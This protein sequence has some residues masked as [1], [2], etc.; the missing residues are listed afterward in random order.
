[1]DMTQGEGVYSGGADSGLARAGP[2]SQH[3]H[4]CACASCDATAAAKSERRKVHLKTTMR[5]NATGRLVNPGQEVR[6][7]EREPGD[8]RG[9]H[10]RRFR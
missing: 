3:P 2:A 8:Q 4:G 9:A 6:D 10:Q 5:F 1:M 7:Q